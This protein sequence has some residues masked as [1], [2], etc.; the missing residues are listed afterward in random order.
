MNLV[1][2]GSRTTSYN[3]NQNHTAQRITNE[4]IASGSQC[5]DMDIAEHLLHRGENICLHSINQAP[6][7]RYKQ[8]SNQ[9]Y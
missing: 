9:Q 7:H 4:L 5:Q 6:D 1:R 3:N 8:K 2:I